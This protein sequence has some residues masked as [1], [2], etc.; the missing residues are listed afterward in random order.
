MGRLPIEL[1]PRPL[2]PLEAEVRAL[3]ERFPADFAPA[4]EWNRRLAETALR[5]LRARDADAD[6]M[7]NHARLDAWHGGLL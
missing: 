7:S 6:S 1:V 2:E 5:R 3:R 4:L